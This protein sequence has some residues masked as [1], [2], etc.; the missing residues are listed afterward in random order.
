[1]EIFGFIL[2][3]IGS[4]CGIIYTCIRV[5]EKRIELWKWLYGTHTKQK[6]MKKANKKNM[7]KNEILS[8]LESGICEIIHV[9][10]NSIEHSIMAT[11]APQHLPDG[12]GLLS[13]STEHRVWVFN[14]NTETQQE[15]MVDSIIEVEQLT[16]EGAVNNEKKLTSSAE[17]IDKLFG[18]NTGDGD[19]DDLDVMEHPEL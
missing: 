5:A 4:I 9:D 6:K 2:L 18:G 8:K 16:G 11:L 19:V 10:E 15:Y 3:L 1:M 12:I 13:D 17:Y 14:V 7:K